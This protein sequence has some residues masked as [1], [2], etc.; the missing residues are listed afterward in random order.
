M[1]NSEC[2]Y[3]FWAVGG[4]IC[5]MRP[6]S[7][8]DADPHS[9]RLPRLVV[10]EGRRRV[11][12]QHLTRQLLDQRQRLPPFVAHQAHGRLVDDRVQ[13]QQVRVLVGAGGHV[14]AQV[15]LQFA[16]LAHHVREV[17]EEAR[18][19]V[20]LQRFDLLRP[21]G[22]VASGQQ[23][24]VLEQAAAADLL[25]V[26]RRDQL[27]VQV[28][29]RLLDVAVH[30]L[31]HHRRVEVVRHGQ[32]AALVEQQQR[33]QHHLRTTPRTNALSHE[34]VCATIGRRRGSCF[35]E[36]MPGGTEST[37]SWRIV[38]DHLEKFDFSKWGGVYYTTLISPLQLVQVLRILRWSITF[39][40][41][42]D[43]KNL[44]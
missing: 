43:W 22:P 26:T 44:R 32:V 30:R 37:R 29:Q 34:T 7:A 6:S 13:Q 28:V 39:C 14:V 11:H 25:R 35:G 21:L 10:E 19:H 2:Q 23:V 42:N 1:L 9:G 5:D 27:L 38:Q 17:D 31:A 8:E 40:W 41:Y 3:N 33:V 18:A 24:A 16:A 15:R 36:G 12:G 20:A 4:S